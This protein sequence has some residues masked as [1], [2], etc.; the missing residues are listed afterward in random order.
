MGRKVANQ[1]EKNGNR[2]A[3]FI[4][5]VAVAVVVLFVGP[6]FQSNFISPDLA[7][8]E[9]SGQEGRPTWRRAPT[10]SSAGVQV[11]KVDVCS[12]IGRLTWRRRGTRMCS[13]EQKSRWDRRRPVGK[14]NHERK[15]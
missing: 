3:R 7:L 11:I 9:T 5:A 2:L 4:L 10:L 14:H 8:R 13:N 12:A 6:L 1:T 15:Q